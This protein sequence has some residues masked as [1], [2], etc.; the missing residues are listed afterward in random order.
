MALTSF[1]RW[2]LIREIIAARRTGRIV[3][4]IGRQYLHWSI[5]TG[6]LQSVSATLPDH[7][8]AEYLSRSAML[9]AGSLESAR[10]QVNDRRTLGSVLVRNSLLTVPE[11]KK[12]YF[13]YCLSL[14]PCLLQS[15]NNLLWSACPPPVKSESVDLSVPLWQLFVAAG[16]EHLEIHAAVE[17]AQRFPQSYRLNGQTVLAERLKHPETRV[18]DYLIRG[19]RLSDILADPDLDRMTCYRFAFLLWLSGFL[20]PTKLPKKTTPQLLAEQEPGSSG[21]LVEPAWVIALIVGM[22]LGLLFAPHHAPPP[23]PA[24]A[25]PEIR[26]P[27]DPP[28]WTPGESLKEKRSAPSLP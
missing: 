28:A 3:V 11:L 20:Q 8:F 4:Q 26:R 15:D 5:A 27:P 14:T 22:M 13:D 18:L 2:E 21:S 10:K 19:A 23:A 25:Q 9:E 17:F 24:V 7:S 16:R 6:R 1:A 12:A